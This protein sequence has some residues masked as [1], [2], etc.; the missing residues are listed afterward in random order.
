MKRYDDYVWRPLREFLRSKKL[1]STSSKDSASLFD[2]LHRYYSLNG[3][4]ADF[5]TLR[6]HIV[7][8]V[9]HRM[10]GG[11]LNDRAPLESRL[12]IDLDVNKLHK[13]SPPPMEISELI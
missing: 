4:K 13:D 1:D 2:A 7:N 12:F 10:G 5:L 11:F 3:G 9:N 6:D 8:S